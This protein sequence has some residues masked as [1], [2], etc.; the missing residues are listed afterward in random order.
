MDQSWLN[1]YKAIKEKFDYTYKGYNLKYLVAGHLGIDF[2]AKPAIRD[3]F[4]GFFVSC[5]FIDLSQALQTDKPT[6]ITYLINRPDYRDLANTAQSR[7][8]ESA[9]VNLSALPLKKIS[10]FSP[11]YIKH[12]FKALF[13]VFGRSI[14][15][16]LNFKLYYAALTILL[17]NQIRAIEKVKTQNKVSRYICFNSSYRD[18]TLLTLYFN[19]RNI[20]TITMQHGIFCEFKRFV[21]FD[22]INSENC[23]AS[24]MLCWGQSTI[25]FLSSRGFTNDRFIV[26]GNL[27]YMDCRIDRVEQ[28][29]KHCL[30]L[31]GRGLYVETN[32][33]LLAALQEYNK[34]HNNQIVFYV[35]KHPFLDDKDHAQF[36]K[37][38]DNMIF[39]GK[40]HSVQ[41]VLD[42]GLV[43][44]SIA[45]NTTA[46]Y[47]SMALGKPCLRWTEEEN[48]DFYGID[49]KFENLQQ[50]EEKISYLK[51]M[52][53][54]ELLQQTKDV[55]RYIFNPNL[56]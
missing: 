31:L 27:K 52:D 9:V 17:L 23:V 45:V 51:N 39:L 34:K 12:F 14:G 16:N 4:K 37:V 35:K 42:S 6:L 32:N 21:P 49:D 5:N 24:K 40:E 44:F 25:D 8:P 18:E 54:Q 30:V 38:A 10:P 56:K 33:K 13:L 29:F 22:I 36:A 1:G 20:E 41:N 53:Q 46:Y 50:F 19:K 55:I 43:D 26:M 11:S 48:E 15:G 7:Y 47:E 2:D 3:V 28:T